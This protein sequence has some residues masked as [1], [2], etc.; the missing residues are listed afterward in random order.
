VKAWSMASL[1][2][3]SSSTRCSKGSGLVAPS[4]IDSVEAV[5][6]HIARCGLAIS[7]PRAIGNKPLVVVRFEF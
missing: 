5:A 1:S 2:M 7:R 3:R 4:R 6:A